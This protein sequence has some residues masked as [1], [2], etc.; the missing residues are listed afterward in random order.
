[1]AESKSDNAQEKSSGVSRRQFVAGTVG[2]VVVGVVVGAAAGSLGFPK[3]VTSTTTATSTS[4]QTSTSTATLTSTSTA[5][6]VSTVTS[7]LVAGLPTS[8]DQTTDVVVIGSGGAGLAAAL[9]ALESGAKVTILEKASTL[10]G[11]TGGSGGGMWIP[12]NYLAVQ[13]GL[14]DTNATLMTYLTAV[15]AGEQNNDLIT[16]YLTEAPVWLEHLNTI[17]KGSLGFYLSPLYNDYYNIGTTRSFGHLVELP[18]YGYG[19]VTAIE[20]IIKGDGANIMVSTPAT[21]LYMDATG[22]VVGV[23]AKS[24]S[25]TINIKANKGVVLAA[26]GYD[27]NAAMMASYPRGPIGGSV[28]VSTNTGDCILMAMGIGAAVANMNNNWGVPVYPTSNGPI[29][30]WDLWRSKPGAIIVNSAGNRFVNE[31]SAYPVANRAFLSWDSATYG[32]PNMPAYTI[33]DSTAFTKYGLAGATTALS[34]LPSYIYTSSTLAGLAAALNINAAGLAATVATFN[35]NAANGV[36]PLFNRGVFSF[37]TV[38]GGDST[39]TDLKNDCLAPLVTAPFYGAEI[40]SGTCGTCGGPVINS[41]GQVL[42]QA[43]NPIPG[44]YGAGNDIAAPWGA[45]YPGGGSTV[46]AATTFGWIAG[47]SVGSL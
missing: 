34:T 27:F 23:Q 10:G 41:S 36:D 37:D 16:T 26:G 18:S 31:S 45:A 6:L 32:Y 44:L 33:M 21:G 25:S 14:T 3:T 38:T 47:K 8:W 40:T 4:T 12:N 9:G 5:T 15:G 22:T 13:Q 7:T 28:A 29:A 2:G 35:T 11:T 39:R 17:T 43:G 24:G 30:D 20:A 46:G 42:D 19:M 1:M